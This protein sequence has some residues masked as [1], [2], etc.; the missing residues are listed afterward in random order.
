MAGPSQKE[1][2]HVNPVP[3]QSFDLHHV[4]R[5]DPLR[6]GRCH[7]DRFVARG[8]D[9]AKDGLLKR[10]EIGHGD[11]HLWGAFAVQHA[12]PSSSA[13]ADDPVTPG[14]KMLVGGYW[15]PRFRGA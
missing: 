2:Y 10:R 12:R 7:T 6:F 1:K 11:G 8:G 15:M 9:L 14:V 13:K 5:H 3:T 4:R